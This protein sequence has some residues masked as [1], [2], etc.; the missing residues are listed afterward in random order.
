MAEV[1]GIIR[2]FTDVVGADIAQANLKALSRTISEL[3]AKQVQLDLRFYVGRQRALRYSGTIAEVTEMLK[4]DR[5]AIESLTASKHRLLAIFKDAEG[6][7]TKYRGTLRGLA[8]SL[9]A[10]VSEGR[11]SI[12]VY[13]ESR[14]FISELNRMVVQASVLTFIWFLIQRRIRSATLRVTKAQEAYNKALREH[15][16]QSAKAIKA[17]RDLQKAQG[18]LRLV[19]LQAQIQ[20]ILF[21]LSMARM[22]F[23]AIDMAKTIRTTVIPALKAQFGATV[24]LAGAKATL[25]SMTGV[26]IPLVI[27]GVSAGVLYAKTMQSMAEAT[28]ELSEVVEEQIFAGK[29][30]FETWEDVVTGMTDATQSELVGK[31]QEAIRRFVECSIDKNEEMV[32]YLST[33]YKEFAEER[34]AKIEAMHRDI[35]RLEEAGMTKEAEALRKHLARYVTESDRKLAKMKDLHKLYFEALREDSEVAVE[36]VAEILE[37][38]LELLIGVKGPTEDEVL[39]THE[40]ASEWLRKA[41]PLQIPVE[42]VPPWLPPFLLPP[43]TRPPIWEEEAGEFQ[44]GGIVPFTGWFR[45]RAGE[46]VLRRGEQIGRPAILS[47]GNITLNFEGAPRI[48]D[49]RRIAESIFIEIKRLHARELG[50][51]WRLA[52]LG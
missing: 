15:G 43:V 13:R 45:L 50:R 10:T 52:R 9:E 36:D 49:A 14:I 46:R 32:L 23:Y 16:P 38:P 1:R 48:E 11:R 20:S 6:T 25:L 42:P 24:A 27:A 39:E 51:R 44:F 5:K 28:A 31:T 26:L 41:G 19:T 35:A 17:G 47:I 8:Q 21:G 7:I 3:A 22:A 18:D 40:K 37:I 29:R 33:E 2:L 34:A 30:M 12:E 4:S